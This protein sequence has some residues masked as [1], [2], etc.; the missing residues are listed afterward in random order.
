MLIIL[1]AYI[2]NQFKAALISNTFLDHVILKSIWIS[3]CN[4]FEKSHISTCSFKPI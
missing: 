4:I 1:K 3:F 2:Y